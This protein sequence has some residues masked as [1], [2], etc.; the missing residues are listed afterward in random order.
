MTQA[1]TPKCT[2]PME[3]VKRH[4]GKP[5]DTGRLVAIRFSTKDRPQEQFVVFA[6]IMDTELN[7][8]RKLTGS[9]LRIQEPV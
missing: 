5:L 1:D 8:A 4:Y 7:S 6:L 9:K 3:Y 2:D